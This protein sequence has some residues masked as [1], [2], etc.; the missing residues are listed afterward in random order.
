MNEPPIPVRTDA[1]LPQDAAPPEGAAAER[2]ARPA[3]A[4]RA[5]PDDAL[6]VLP[7]RNVVMFPGLV[8]PMQIGRESS[9]AA[10]RSSR[11]S[12]AAIGTCT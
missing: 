3:G 5:L 8:L 7:A 1:P 2:P 9:R 6:I 12:S 11:A 10:T 4:A